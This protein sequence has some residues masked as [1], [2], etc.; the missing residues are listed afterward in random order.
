MTN[1]R[2]RTSREQW[3]SRFGFLMAMVGA[4]V[5]AGNIWRL[6]YVTG[7]NGGGG[8]LLIYL[9]LLYL[10]AVPGLMAETLLGR[11]TNKGVIG[12]VRQVAGPGGWTGVGIVVLVVNVAL[13]SYYAPILGWILYYV[14]HSILG[15]FVQP[16]FNPLVFWTSYTNATALVIATHT[17]AVGLVATVLWFGIRD[18]IERIVRWLFPALLVAL[19]AVAIRSLTLPGALSG[20]RYLFTPRIEFLVRPATWIGALGQALF[21]TGL[22]WGIALTYGS[23]LREHDDVALG[24]GL[25]TALG[26]TSIG[27][28]ALLA[29]FPAVFAVGLQPTA[30]SSLT[31]ISLTYVFGQMTGGYFWAIVF[32]L[33]FFFAAFTSGL[34]ITE[35]GVTTLT[36]ETRFDRNTVVVLFSGA[37]WLLGLPSAYS[38]DVLNL[39]DFIFGTWGLPVAALL[40]MLVVGWKLGRSPGLGLEW[41]RLVE[42]NRSTDLYVG[43]WWSVIVQFVIPPV[44]AVII[45]YYVLSNLVS[46]PTQTV[47][48][49]VLIGAIILVSVLGMAVLERP[50][51]DEHANGG[52][53]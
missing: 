26:N 45:V 4:M 40:L 6:P 5:G 36:E 23:Y 50:G 24:G 48:G 19:I 39:L 42:L 38:V 3:G 12:S 2:A 43:R 16:G 30:G 37:I 1:Q 34:A 15:T 41:V 44:I 49:V 13:M 7:I 10:I 9:L 46:H 32:Y 21:S 14:Y 35:V 51:A 29:V 52:G 53:Q 33:G 27:L 28:L 11:Y 17:I 31:F 25:F 20:V 22:G 18:G 47:G 8:F